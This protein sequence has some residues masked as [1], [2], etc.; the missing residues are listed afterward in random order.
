MIT[1][2]LI[3]MA[4]VEKK[5]P[6]EEIFASF[7]SHFEAKIEAMKRFVQGTEAKLAAQIEVPQR[8]TEASNEPRIEAANKA[9]GPSLLRLP[10]N[11]DRAVQKAEVYQLTD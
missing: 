7:S 10:A 3:A 4:R 6:K 1:G 11:A 2:F 9:S 8:G 5:A